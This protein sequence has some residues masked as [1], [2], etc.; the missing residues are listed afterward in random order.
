MPQKIKTFVLLLALFILGTVGYV[1]SPAMAASCLPS[2]ANCTCSSQGC[3]NGLPVKNPIDCP[4]GRVDPND[5]SKCA[6]L[7]NDCNG[8][9]NNACLKKNPITT[10]IND[11]IA[12][13]SAGVGIIVIGTII[14]GGI[15]YSMAG[16]NPT[17]TQAAR[18]R[19]TNGLIALFAFLF[20]F[21]FLQWLVPGGL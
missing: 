18:Q 1:K 21:A 11:A 12:F 16:D 17:A 10:Y 15:Q 6:P 14:L 3:D 19:I 7:G 9:N 5:N 13:L 20:I 4:S 8:L 2:T